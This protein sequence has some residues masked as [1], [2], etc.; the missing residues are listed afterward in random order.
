MLA[1]EPAFESTDELEKL[2]V[3]L[4]DIELELLVEVEV[5]ELELEVVLSL[6]E[7]GLTEELRLNLTPEN[8]KESSVS[9][10]Y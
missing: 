10:S 1:L 8:S 3:E 7:L 2:E 6:K 5:L 4:L 9:S